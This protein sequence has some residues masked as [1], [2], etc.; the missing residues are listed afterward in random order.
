MVLT[1]TIKMPRTSRAMALRPVNSLKHVVDI[2]GGLIAGTQSVTAII[3]TV[4]NPVQT[5]SND[6]A[7]ASVVKSLF[8]NVQVA[9]TGT[10]AL[11][12]VYLMLYKNPGNNI[13]AANVPNAN[14]VGTSDFRKMVFH[15][16]MIMTEKNTTAIPRTLFKGVLRI[17]KHM[18]RMGV[19]DLVAVALFS[20]GVNFDF[21]FQV[22]YKEFR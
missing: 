22:I 20:P 10:A 17:P 7:T 2:Q 14:V 4:D 1:M 9:A 18:Q 6:V 13:G 19:D 21:C 8:L 12:N 3:D 11:A 16:E 5:N 15:Q